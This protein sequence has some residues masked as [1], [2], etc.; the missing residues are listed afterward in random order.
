MK[1][2][3]KFVQKLY[4]LVALAAGVGSVF[5]DGD[6]TACVFMAPLGLWLMF[7]KEIVID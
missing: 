5:V 7:T 2:K 3:R 4:G 6:A 1:L